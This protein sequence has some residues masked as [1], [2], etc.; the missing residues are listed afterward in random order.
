[1]TSEMAY[2]IVGHVV[3]VCLH[4]VLALFRLKGFQDRTKNAVRLQ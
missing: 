1:M 3:F 4:T 2:K